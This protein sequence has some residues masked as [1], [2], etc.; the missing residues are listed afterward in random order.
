M[1]DVILIPEG[2]TARTFDLGIGLNR[3]YPMQTALGLTTP[4]PVVRTAKGPPHVGPSGWL[5]HL[6]APNLLLTS[7]R[8]APDG[9][10]SLV[11]RFLECSGHSGQAEFRCV[12]DPQRATLLDARG[13]LLMEATTHGDAVTLDAGQNDLIHLRVDFAP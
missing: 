8:P 4:V 1:L 2:E 7:L 6:D 13:N 5:F 10:A 3:E 12:R 9:S 11:A